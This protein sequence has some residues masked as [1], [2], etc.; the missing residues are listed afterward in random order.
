MKDCCTLQNALQL[1]THPLDMDLHDNNLLINI[2]SSKIARDKCQVQNSVVIGSKQY[3]KFAESL[4]DGFYA[5]IQ[6]KVVTIEVKEKRKGSLAGNDIY[7]TEMLYLCV[8][9]LLSVGQISL[10]DLFFYELSPVP[11]TIFTVTGEG[12]F[13]KDKAILNKQL[14]LLLYMDVQHCTT[15]IDQKMQ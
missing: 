11:M 10:E 9:C 3:I 14:M 5:T 13:Q 1:C 6:K 2:Y 12:R 15:F 4:S 7:N 8:M